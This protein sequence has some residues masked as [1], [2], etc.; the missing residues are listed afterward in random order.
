MHDEGGRGG[1]P[2]GG[3]SAQKLHPRARAGCAPPSTRE[4]QKAARHLNVLHFSANGFE[5]TPYPHQKLQSAPDLS[6]LGGP[7]TL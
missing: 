3:A 5:L 4:Q 6:C 7:G 1:H 2:A